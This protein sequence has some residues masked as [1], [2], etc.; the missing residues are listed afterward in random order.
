MGDFISNENKC[1]SYI[2]KLKSINM[3]FRKYTRVIIQTSKIN[4]KFQFCV[5]VKYFGSRDERH[6][7]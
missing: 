4:E 3:I 6:N 5:P 7:L 2:G 1:Y